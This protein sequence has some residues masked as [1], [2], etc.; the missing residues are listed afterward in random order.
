LAA[1]RYTNMLEARINGASYDQLRAM[2]QV[3]K[4]IQA[5]NQII[6]DAA[7]SDVIRLVPAAIAWSESDDPYLKLSLEKI[8]ILLRSQL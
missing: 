1:V 8:E 3:P 6:G 7:P 5:A 2:P 4:P